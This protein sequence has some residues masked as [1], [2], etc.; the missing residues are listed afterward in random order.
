[1]YLYDKN[2]KTLTFIRNIETYV[3]IECLINVL[4]C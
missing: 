1:M 2:K 4:A 3:A